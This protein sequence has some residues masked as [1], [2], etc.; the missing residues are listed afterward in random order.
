MHQWTHAREPLPSG[1]GT[2]YLISESSNPLNFLR[3]IE[4]LATDAGFR[5]F[6]THLLAETG[7]RAFRWETP[8]LDRTRTTRPFEFVLIDDP[9]LERNADSAVFASYFTGI[10]S[11]DAVAVVPNLGRTSELIVPRGIAAPSAYPHFAAFLRNA[12][13]TQVDVLWRCVADT[14]L[15]SLSDAPLWL[16][17]AGAGVAW[18]HVRVDRVPKYY[19]HRPYA[20]T[21]A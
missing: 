2:R 13:E 8:P 1:R 16:S 19:T 15:R 12:P 3:A 11:N 6:M 4:L 10:T 14:V 7:Y 21:A 17:T 5:G 20:A 9:G 18:L